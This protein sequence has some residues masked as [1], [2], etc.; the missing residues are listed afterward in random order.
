MPGAVRL[1]SGAGNPFTIAPMDDRI[2]LVGPLNLEEV[3]R[4]LVEEY[5]HEVE[6]TI[7][8]RISQAIRADPTKHDV[9]K[10]VLGDLLTRSVAKLQNLTCGGSV[11]WDEMV[12]RP[13]VYDSCPHVVVDVVDGSRN[14]LA[15]D[16]EVT[17]TLGIITQDKSM[18]ITVVSYPFARE[19]IV[20]L[21]GKVYRL[22]TEF[23]DTPEFKLEN[24]HRYRMR[25]REEKTKVEQLRIS[26]RYDFFPPS[27]D[28]GV[29]GMR[30]KLD[31]LRGRVRSTMRPAGSLA[32]M[33]LSVVAGACD[34]IL[35][36]HRGRDL[37]YYDTRVPVQIVRDLDGWVTDLEGAPFEEGKASVPG[38]IVASRKRTHDL[39]TQALWSSSPPP[40]Q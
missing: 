32:K 10:E 17:S 24:A 6:E 36:K 25:P 20:D 8:Y 16:T 34:A 14:L 15:G 30:E 40:P 18:P 13:A 33:I 5:F 7:R 31:A 22:P 1:L 35:I 28:G 2:N 26:E 3:Y 27:V 29:G 21:D 12:D 38:I 11:F 37:D 23:S 19:R 39:F 4:T 9:V